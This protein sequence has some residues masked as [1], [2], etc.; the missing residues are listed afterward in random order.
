M[1][2]EKE[3]CLEAGYEDDV[4]GLGD[5]EQGVEKSGVIEHGFE[6]DIP[7]LG[8]EEGVNAGVIQE[9]MDDT[10][11]F[12]YHLNEQELVDHNDEPP[13]VDDAD[14]GRFQEG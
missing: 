7:S 9:S 5:I 4:P 3:S 8:V 10:F 12:H 2:C 13:Q 14:L 11:V 6:D 1:V